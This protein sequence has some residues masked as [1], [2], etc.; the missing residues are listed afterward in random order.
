M[1]Q[2]ESYKGIINNSVYEFIHN[3]LILLP[4]FQNNFDYYQG[5]ENNGSQMK[6]AVLTI[7]VIGFLGSV[8]VK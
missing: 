2:A 7:I 3:K 5:Q 4:F 1:K 6:E 8:L